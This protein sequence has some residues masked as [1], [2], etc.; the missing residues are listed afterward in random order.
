M[1]APSGLPALIENVYDA[2]LDPALWDKAVVG[3]RDFVGGQACGLF[4]KDQISKFGV[5]HYYCGADTH[6]IQMY[7]ETHCKFDPLTVLPAYGDVVSIPDLVDFEEYRKGRFYQEWLQPQ[8][9]IDAANVVLEKSNSS[10]PVLMT[11]LVGRDM[12]DSEM[13]KRISLIVPH[14]NRALM[15]NRALEERQCEAACFVETLNGLNAGIF[16]LDAA[17]RIVHANIAGQRLLESD[18]PL[19]EV[20]GQLVTRDLAVNQSLRKVFD[21]EGS[22]ALAAADRAF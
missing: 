8:G 1:P 2:A 14:A 7:A 9:C 15:I 19:R 10:F 4:S 11:V 20:G 12:V 3:I 5:T 13:R 22:V 21:T 16:L 17:C 18:D 6:Y